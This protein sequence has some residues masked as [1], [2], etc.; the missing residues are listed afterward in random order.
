M[1]TVTQRTSSSSGLA[2]ASP[3]SSRASGWAGASFK[4]AAKD[5]Q[6]VFA[7]VSLDDDFYVFSHRG[8][9]VSLVHDLKREECGLHKT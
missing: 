2:S 7:E 1:R 8:T 3:K 9:A 5:E 4:G 6:K